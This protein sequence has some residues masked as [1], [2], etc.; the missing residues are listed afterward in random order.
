[1]SKEERI[2]PPLPNGSI[3]LDALHAADAKAKTDLVE[4]VADAVVVP[5][6]NPKP[7]PEA[8]AESAKG[9]AEPAPPAAPDAA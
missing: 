7:E 4:A 1:M 5:E 3:D 2:L 6:P 8:E 9:K